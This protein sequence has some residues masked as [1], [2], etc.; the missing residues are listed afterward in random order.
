LTET[1]AAK[2]L[3][4]DQPKVSALLR[5]KLQDFSTERLMRFLNALGQDIEIVVRPRPAKR[6]RQHHAIRVVDAA[7]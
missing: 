3:G 5:G 4:V 1:S 7:A 6:S 2:R